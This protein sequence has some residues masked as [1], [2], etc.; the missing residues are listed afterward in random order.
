[1]SEKMISFSAVDSWFFRETRPMDASGE[2]QSIFPPGIR[3]VS[4]AIRTWI[5][6]QQQ[7]DWQAFKSDKSHPL[8]KVIGSSKD[9]DLGALS[10]KGVWISKQGKR[11]Y[12]AP[13]HLMKNEQQLYRLQLVEKGIICDLGKNIRL[14]ELP[15]EEAKGSKPLEN[16]WVDEETLQAILSGEQVDYDEQHFFT[17]DSLFSR[18][19]RTGIARDNALRTD[20]ESMLYQTQHIRPVSEIMLEVDVS[21]LPDNVVSGNALVR[22][23][24]ESRAASLVVNE[25]S[26]ALPAIKINSTDL[27][28]RQ[29]IIIYLLSPLQMQYMNYK[30]QPLPDFG[31][32]EQAKKSSYWKGNIAGVDLKLHGAVVGKSIRDG[33]WDM[34]KHQPRD[35]R[36]L[37]PAGSVFFCEVSN[38]SIADAIDA[39]HGKQLGELQQYGYGQIAVGIWNK[40]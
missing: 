17:A 2:S 39:L 34:A 33:G 23:G 19:T 11:L 28:D 18:E 37:I 26:S 40:G 22:L 8:R 38:G 21:G 10:F 20:K 35:D 30:N 15:C 29:G 9:D 24:G 6:E 13:L 4:G 31:F 36:S 1:M 16:T 3:T 27:T 14:P 5:G 32:V 7:V 25:K 12:P